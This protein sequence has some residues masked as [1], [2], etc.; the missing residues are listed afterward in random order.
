LFPNWNIFLSL[1][2]NL[3]NSTQKKLTVRKDLNIISYIIGMVI[4]S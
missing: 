2:F 4:K 3:K 1:E